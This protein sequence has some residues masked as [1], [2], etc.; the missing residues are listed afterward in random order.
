MDNLWNYTKAENEIL[1][2]LIVIVNKNPLR[3]ESNNKNEFGLMI[4]KMLNIDNNELPVADYNGI[5]LKCRKLNS[6]YALTLFSCNFDG[7]HV[8]E[9]QNVFNRFSTIK[10]NESRVFTH[11]FF[12]NKYTRIN[13]YYAKLSIDISI[14]IRLC[15][16]DKNKAILYN[17]SYWS[18]DLI[19]ERINSKLKYIVIISYKIKYVNNIKHYDIKKIEF[20]KFKNLDSFIKLIDKGF[21]FVSTSITSTIIEGKEKLYNH[22]LS[23]CIDYQNLDQLFIKTKTILL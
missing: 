16:Y 5:E 6:N 4:E 3:S 15:F 8:L 20:Y 23:F 12:S 13:N 1:T 2:N 14:G 9:L 21:I 7:E 17:K 11:S 10:N 18:F 22:G 19:N